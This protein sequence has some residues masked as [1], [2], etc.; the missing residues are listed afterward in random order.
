[1][2]TEF[3]INDVSNPKVVLKQLHLYYGKNKD[4]ELSTR[5][6]KKYMVKN[7]DGKHIHFGDIRYEDVTK[8]KDKKRQLNYLKRA[9]NIKGNWKKDIYSPHFL[10]IV[11]LWNGYH[12]LREKGIV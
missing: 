5:K 9:S 12:Y 2:N 6:N 1:M 8:H 11:L 3:D 10:S 7:N 4:L